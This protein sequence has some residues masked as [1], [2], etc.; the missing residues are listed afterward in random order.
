MA[1]L[2]SAQPTL[3]LIKWVVLQ[4]PPGSYITYIARTDYSTGEMLDL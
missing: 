1:F 4:I 2:S 3:L